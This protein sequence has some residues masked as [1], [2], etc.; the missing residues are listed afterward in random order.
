MLRR[1]AGV[2]ITCTVLSI[3]LLALEPGRLQAQSTEGCVA[4]GEVK[5]ALDALPQF[6]QVNQTYREF[7]EQ[8]L[9]GLRALRE[10]Y[11][12]DLFVN[13]E[14]ISFMSDWRTGDQLIAEYKSLEEKNGS[15]PEYLYLYG[16]TLMGRRTTEEIWLLDQALEKAPNFAWPHLALSSIYAAANLRDPQ[17]QVTHVKAFL[18]MCPSSL[19]G[20]R[21][22][23]RQPVDDPQLT[24]ESAKRL[25]ALLASRSDAEAVNA[26]PVLWGL[27]F[28]SRPPSEYPQARQQVGE[29]LKRIRSLDLAGKREWYNALEEGYKLVGDQK[30]ADWAKEQRQERVPSPWEFAAR[31]EWTKAHKRPEADDPSEKKKAYYQ[32]LLNATN[33]WLKERPNAMPVWWDRMSAAR[34]LQDIP[35]TD[36]ESIGEGYLKATEANGPRGVDADDLFAVAELYAERGIRPGRVLELAQRGLGQFEK[37]AQQPPSD[38]FDDEKSKAHRAFYEESTRARGLILEIR[39]TLG[40]EDAVKAES[41]LAKLEL[42][43]R[44]VK[45]AAGDEEWRQRTFARTEAA[46]WELMAGVAELRGRRQDAMAFYEDGLLADLRSGRRPEPENKNDLTIKARRLWDALGG[47]EQAWQAWYGSKAAAAAASRTNMTWA[48]IN[49]PLPP[50]QLVDLKGKTWTVAELKGKVTLLNFWASW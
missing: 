18:T 5:S 24:R 7:H 46:Y 15:S 25:R 50:F 32:A 6:Q 1:V 31:E 45:G 42:Q 33:Q 4:S 44:A 14:Y 13:R 38:L 43:L 2:G 21:Q 23:S 39:G 41:L 19:M 20:Y 16:L 26:Y 36:V 8:K 40:L 11:P 34:N 28:R 3:L 37:E 12:N 9:A 10:R 47:T 17:K 48:K 22:L 29:D 27:E 49:K 35:P 30:S